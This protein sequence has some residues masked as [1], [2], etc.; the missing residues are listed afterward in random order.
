MTGDANSPVSS[1]WCVIGLKAERA[2]DV[3]LLADDFAG[4]GPAASF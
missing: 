2:G 3:G 1:S 4:V